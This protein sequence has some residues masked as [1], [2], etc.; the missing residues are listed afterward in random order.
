MAK[1]NSFNISLTLGG[2]TITSSA[3]SLLEALIAL[4]VPRKIVTKGVLVASK[5]QKK[6]ELFYPPMKIKS[7]LYP[8][9]RFYTAKKLET[10]LK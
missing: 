1:K 8:I 4:G 6:V 5:G 10:L 2:E 3:P 9:A 7:L